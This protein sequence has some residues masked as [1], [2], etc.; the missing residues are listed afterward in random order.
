MVL[1]AILGGVSIAS[2]AIIIGAPV[3]ITSL[4]LSLMFS[5][6]KGNLKNI[7][8]KEKSMIKIIHQQGVN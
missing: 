5:M 3:G 7:K 1:S 2:V 6:S 8:K 4:R